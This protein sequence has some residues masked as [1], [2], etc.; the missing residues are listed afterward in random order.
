MPHFPYLQI[1][2]ITRFCRLFFQTP[3]TPIT[4]SRVLPD[5]LSA[6]HHISAHLILKL[7]CEHFKPS[8]YTKT[9][10]C[11]S[12]RILNNP[13]LFIFAFRS[14]CFLASKHI[15]NCFL[16]QY[17]IHW[18]DLMACYCLSVTRM[19]LLCT[20]PPHTWTSPVKILH[21]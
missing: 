13:R 10:L 14:F 21:S 3:L 8:I 12:S 16:S 2:L 15:P 19:F 7:N 11:F 1:K 20:P 17:F 4:K 18:P 9:F 5:T 6:P